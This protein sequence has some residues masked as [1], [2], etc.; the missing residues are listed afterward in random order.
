[1]TRS[2]TLCIEG[3]G[4][5]T[6]ISVLKGLSHQKRYEY[7]TVVLD[8]DNMVAG[9]F[10]A[11]GFHKTIGSKDDRYIDVVLDLCRSEGVNVY[12][13]II[14]YGFVKLSQARERF[15]AQGVYLMIAPPESIAVC[16][17]KVETFN[18]FRKIGVPTPDTRAALK[19]G[20]KLDLPFPLILKP[21]WNGRATLDVYKIQSNE[22]LAF[23]TRGTEN[24]LLQTFIDGQEF[25][26]DC[27]ST[28]DGSRFV[29]CAVRLRLET[30]GGLAVK[31]A[32]AEE[33]D[34]VRVKAHI[35]TIAESLKLPGIYNIQGFLAKKRRTVFH[36]DQPALRRRARPH[37]PHRAE[38]HRA[39]AC[40]AGW[41]FG[42]GSAKP[43]PFQS[44]NQNGALL[45][46]AVRRRRPCLGLGQFPS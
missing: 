7:R 44:Q 19:P 38:Q 1:M 42:R 12:L 21:R 23:Y 15:A 18:H 6:C 39:F 35:K 13:P 16:A 43:Y 25:T 8:M 24:Y 10:L 32:L 33:A 40:Y 9:R 41:C 28:P 14:D 26:A 17:D 31:S 22:E 2:F 34:T 29:D 20:D 3:A 46:G 45:D 27:L 5:A 30:K 4:T 11:D 36:R 37:H